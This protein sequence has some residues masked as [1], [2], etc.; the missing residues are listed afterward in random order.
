V[1]VTGLVYL[2]SYPRSGNTLLR[3]ILW[4]CFGLKTVSAY[5]ESVRLERCPA[6]LSLVGTVE[7]WNKALLTKINAEQGVLP[8]KTHDHPENTPDPD[9][10]AIYI[11]RDGREVCVSYWR[12]Q[13]DVL[14]DRAITLTDVIRGQCQFGSW[15]DHV[16]AWNPNPPRWSRADTGS[17]V[18]YQ[19]RENG[20]TGV[21]HYETMKA[22]PEVAARM[23]WHKLGR[24]PT[25]QA[26]TSWDQLHKADPAFFRSG[27][28][29]TWRELMTNDDL[30]LFW[31]LHGETMREYGYSEEACYANA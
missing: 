8:F 9:A 24:K 25:G 29:D 16:K 20:V 15:S 14:G 31:D 18:A 28:N 2:A 19:N 10:P 3:M 30:T 5:D 17:V 4:Q 7:H 11:I 21:F 13:R 26:L 1:A 27:S 6:W 22:R 12:Y 23:I